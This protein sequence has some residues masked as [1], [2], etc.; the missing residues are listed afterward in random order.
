M[1]FVKK[2]WK[3]AVAEFP[4]RRRLTIVDGGGTSDLIVDVNKNEGEVPQQGIL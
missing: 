1:G 4:G 3:K 2:V